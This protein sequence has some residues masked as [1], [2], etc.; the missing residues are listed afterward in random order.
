ML[1]TSRLLLPITFVL[2][3]AGET[4]AAPADAPPTAAGST[5]RVELEEAAAPSAA[6][7]MARRKKALLDY[8]TGATDEAFDGMR[9]AVLGCE[10]A[11]PEICPDASRAVLYRDLGII[12][13]QGKGRHDAAVQAFK[14][15]L[16]LKPNITIPEAYST[17]KTSGAFRAAQGH[18]PAPPAAGAETATAKAAAQEPVASRPDDDKMGFV[19]FDAVGRVGW[20]TAQTCSTYCYTTGYFFQGVG[21]DVTIGFTPAHGAFAIAAEVGGGAYTSSG[22][23][24]GYLDA[25]LL[26]GAILRTSEPGHF[27]YVLG[28]A[29]LQ[30]FTQSAGGG[31]FGGRFVGGYNWGG[32]DL[33]GT[34]DVGS[35]SGY[36]ALMFGLRLGYGGLF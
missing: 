13:A 2:F 20:G 3:L 31:F 34:I 11:G 24:T 6:D 22:S 27:G 8:D 33:G 26:L 36:T 10:E 5:E 1:R 29:A 35:L 4:L 30:P 15:S 19:L 12:L 25:S 17:A 7:I 16:V 14:K 21:V 18:E 23:G 28:G 9:A 32:F